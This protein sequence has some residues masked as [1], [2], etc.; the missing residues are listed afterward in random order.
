MYKSEF[1]NEISSRGFIYQA[2]DIKELD[3]LLNKKSITA[4]IGFDITSDSLHIGSLVQLMLLHWLDFYGHKTIAL[5]GGGTT[6][7]GDPSGKDETRK[8]LNLKDIEKNISKIKKTFKK[9][10]DLNK[11]G[12]LINN[13]KW[14]SKINYINFLRDVGSK[15]TINKMLTFESVKNRL[16]R[17]QPL[18]FL[19]FNYM[20]LQ[21]YDYYHLNKE[22]GCELQLGG[23]DQWGNILSGI[24]L[25]R[26]LNNEKTF[27]ITSPLIT[28]NDGSKMGKTADGAIW[29]DE[30]KLSNYNF[31]QFWRNIDDSNVE[32]FLNLF[33]KLPIKEIQ[34]LSN[35]KGKEI[36]ESKKILAFEVTKIARGFKQAKEASEITE[37]IFKNKST[38]DRISSYKVS[39]K[40]INNSS[41]TILDAIE[42]LKLVK[43]RSETK[44]LIKSNGI[45]VN[46]KNYNENDFSLSNYKVK[47][48]IKINVGKKKVGFIKITK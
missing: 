47:G 41:F 3:I 33:T 20:L 39:D 42:K 46:E 44:R 14:L 29:L 18:S 28:N 15:I 34:K 12:K 31:Y 23:S 19:E 26:R 11:N 6:L 7:I 45:K 5:M 10:I 32:K 16:D 9:Y 21:A 27:A 8:I 30:R 37:N 48:E 25:I 13:Y 36:N 22:Y 24:D 2:S 17:E 35:L 40:L 38:D 1:L 4:Y 43:S